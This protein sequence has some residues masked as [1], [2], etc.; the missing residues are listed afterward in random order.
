MNKVYIAARYFRRSEMIEKAAEL[1]LM[2]QKVTSR[3]IK[4]SHEGV[5]DSECA[6]NDE[7]DIRH[8]DVVIFFAESAGLGDRGGGGRHV[9]FGMAYALNKKIIV[10]GDREN[11]FHSL[12]GVVLAKDWNATKSLISGR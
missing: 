8:S 2:G 5:P 11:L 1:E 7:A 3:W 12:P 6:M 10:V 9:E 4:E